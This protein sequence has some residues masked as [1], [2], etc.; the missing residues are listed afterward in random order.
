MLH[1][2][3]D[4]DAELISYRFGHNGNCGWSRFNLNVLYRLKS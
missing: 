3:S 4:Y 2:A 1:E